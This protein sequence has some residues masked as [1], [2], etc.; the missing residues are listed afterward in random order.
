MAGTD[1][2]RWDKIAIVLQPA[3]GLLTALAVAFVGIMGS[4]Y[5]NR[6]QAQDAR[7]RLFT[8]LMSRREQSDTALREDMF[9]SIVSTFLNPS[10]AKL[11][12]KVLSL[13]LLA[14][15][16]HESLELAPLFKHVRREI[17]ASQD[18]RKMEYH[19]RLENIAKEVAG[20]QIE[21]LQESGAFVESG[22]DLQ[23][24]QAHREGLTVLDKCLALHS[25]DVFRTAS[26]NQSTT[27]GH[28]D[29]THRCIRADVMEADARTQRLLIHLQST[30]QEGENVDSYFW[31]DFYDLPMVNNTRLSHDQRIAVVLKKYD[32]TSAQLG[33]VYFPGSRASVKDKP[34]Y[35]DMLHQLD[36]KPE[37][38]DEIRH[39]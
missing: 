12:Q 7:L 18:R 33:F 8:E 38:G 22:M 30:T 17:E 3:G 5:L 27:E 16:F 14:D 29:E 35:D 4:T 25:E 13:E 26:M 19:K 21:V 28:L 37:P 24:V 1:K 39:R 15:N 31:V 10:T 32:E 36:L 20:K 2:T 34:F 6:N 23:D 9:K 11:E